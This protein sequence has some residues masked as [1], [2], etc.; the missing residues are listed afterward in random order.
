MADPITI[1]TIAT[2]VA[3]GASVSNTIN[4]I[5]DAIL[6]VIEYAF[7]RLDQS[8]MLAAIEAR[9]TIN[10]S[11]IQLQDVMD[12][13]FEE[14]DDSQR[15]IIT[16]LDRLIDDLEDFGSRSISE[17]RSTVRE[18]SSNIKLLYSDNPGALFIS[19]D[20]ILPDENQV[21]IKLVGSA[22]SNIKENEISGLRI[23]SQKT[24]FKI[25]GQ[26]DEH[27]VIGIDVDREF[28]GLVDQEE[29][30]ELQVTFSIL[31]TK[32]FGWIKTGERPFS[33]TAVFLPKQL[34]YIRI[35]ITGDQEELEK[36]PRSHKFVTKRAK[37][38]KFGKSKSKKQPIAISPS[39]G[40]LIDVT[41]VSHRFTLLNSG[42]SG[43]R[44]QF[45]WLSKHPSGIRAEMKAAT[46][47]K[48][49]VTCKS[50]AIISYNE[51]KK[52]DKQ[53][54]LVSDKSPLFSD[55]TL[56]FDLNSIAQGMTKIRFSHLEFD[57]DALEGGEK[58]VTLENEHQYPFDIKYE[59]GTQ[60]L[61]INSSYKK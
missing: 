5:K 61:F 30:V 51:Y 28:L 50:E 14:L 26:D 6:E 32:I 35:V 12:S 43:S 48:P 24:D 18:V 34:G 27:I 58:V 56:Q 29:I 23:N 13:T 11:A 44:S 25:L 59:V 9:N 10:Q 16:D 49:S 19:P 55:E 47:R 31:E 36:R 46:D 40:F 7:D 45:R 21:K 53:T 60:M 38:S 42:C 54:T 41:S 39:P 2:G 3:K 4:S 20:V 15:K 22:V 52:T 1:G 8:L 17:I 33:T 37:S 57:S